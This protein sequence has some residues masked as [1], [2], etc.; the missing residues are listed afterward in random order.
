[1]LSIPRDLWVP[2]HGTSRSNK[3]NSAFNGG[4]E[5]L[6]PTVSG[7][8]GIPIDHYVQMDFNGFR[9]L[10][11]AV[12][13]VN[14]YVPS[15]ARDRQTGLFIPDP[16]CVS[17]DGHMALAWVRSREYQHMEG[18]RW[19]TDPTADHG[20]IQR[21]QDFI[22]RLMREAAAD[23]KSLNIFTIK[24]MVNTAVQ[25]VQIDE[26]FDEDQLVGLARRFRSLE[27]DAVEMLTLPTTGAGLRGISALKIKQPD[28]QPI[29]DRFIAAPEPSEEPP[30]DVHPNS[31]GMR[32][33]NGSGQGG[34]A[35]DAAAGLRA[36]GFNIRGVG[37]ADR[38]NYQSTVIRYGQGQRGKALLVSSKIQGGA[39][40]QEA[41]G[42]L[43][44]DL[45][46][47]TGTGFQGIAA[48]ASSP[49]ADAPTSAPPAT[50][51]QRQEAAPPPPA[52]PAC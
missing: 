16:G 42:L 1:M 23:A 34:Q 48:A 6:I 50:E 24:D 43:G 37:D 10:V 46:L 8:L 12:G 5:Q 38:F 11:E 29:L 2:I 52:E 3:I 47:I 20:R 33:L 31:V 14:M 49:P 28:A 4:P 18:G 9:G 40:L 35:G 13:G 36:H 41:S 39:Q 51:A 22:R 15:P 26:G 27:P 44:V 30:P 32:V 45:V 17:F 25:N 21:Q 7:A 19:R